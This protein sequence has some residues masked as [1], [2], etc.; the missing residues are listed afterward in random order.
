MYIYICVCVCIN[1]Y[2]CD[3]VVSLAPLKELHLRILITMVVDVYRISMIHTFETNDFSLL[4]IPI[5]KT[6]NCSSPIVVL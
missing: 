1:E 5:E 6:K 3:E 4:K 2:L